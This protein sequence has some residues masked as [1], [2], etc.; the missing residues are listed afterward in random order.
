MNSSVGTDTVQRRRHDGEHT[1]ARVNFF[2]TLI[3][4]ARASSS[5]AIPLVFAHQ[6]APAVALFRRLD[7]RPSRQPGA[8][9]LAVRLPSV[10]PA[11]H[12]EDRQAP[13]AA[14]LS[15]RLHRSP[16]RR[17]KLARRAGRDDA[18]TCSGAVLHRP[19]RAEALSC[20]SGPH[21][22]G[23][24]GAGRSTPGPRVDPISA[25]SSKTTSRRR[26]SRRPAARGPRHPAFRSGSRMPSTGLGRRRAAHLATSFEHAGSGTTAP[27]SS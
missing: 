1:R 16:V 5:A 27:S 26:R 14:L 7:A 4:D 23:E 8:V 3:P 6:R 19:R 13:A 15:E 2:G 22:F 20:S 17:R 25:R 9:R 12:V 21:C 11:T 10:A 18:A 24:P